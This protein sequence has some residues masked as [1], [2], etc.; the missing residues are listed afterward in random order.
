VTLEGHV[1]KGPFVRGSTLIVYEL[2]DQFVPTGKSF[3]TEIL[4]DKG[5][6]NLKAIEISSKYVQ[7]TASGYYFD[8]ITAQ[9]SK[10]TISLNAIAEV[11][12]E[13]TININVLTHLE[14]KRVRNLIKEGKEFTEAK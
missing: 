14:E 1:E 11:N 10:S 13:K 5:S 12:S 8:E 9:L 2:N 3:K 6:F 4:D 7:I